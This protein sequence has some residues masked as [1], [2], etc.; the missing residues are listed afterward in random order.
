MNPEDVL[1]NFAELSVALLGFS[2]IVS[3]FNARGGWTPDGRFWA[4]LRLGLAALGFSLLPLPFLAAGLSTEVVW[5]LTSAV[6]AT[7]GFIYVGY[8]LR[9]A[10]KSD[11]TG[12]FNRPLFGLFMASSACAA[13]LLAFNVFGARAFWPYLAALAWFVF[14]PAVLFVR[15][16]RLWLEPSRV[17]KAS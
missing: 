11:T 2:G 5:S 3:I 8:S 16:L 9:V 15:L 13:C 10:P 12:S 7:Y 4:V 14:H 6:F 17:K 1:T